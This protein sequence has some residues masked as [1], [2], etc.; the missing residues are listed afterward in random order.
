MPSNTTGV[1][2]LILAMYYIAIV[3]FSVFFLNIFIGARFIP[4]TLMSRPVALVLI[5]LSM[6]CC[7]GVQV[8][9]LQY[10]D[11][12]NDQYGILI[13]AVLFHLM[14]LGAHQIPNCRFVGGRKE[15]HFLWVAWPTPSEEPSQEDRI[16]GLMGDRIDNIET[17][18]G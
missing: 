9:G 10:G 4:C 1:P 14:F 15:P 12:Y 18:I 16:E 8:A 2:S 6:A 3:S 7:L 17:M 11:V 13:F 5:L